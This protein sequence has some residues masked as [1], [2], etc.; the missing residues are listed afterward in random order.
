MENLPIPPDYEDLETKKRIEN[1]NA[2][3]KD[4][5]RNDENLNY[6]I[7]IF[8]NGFNFDVEKVKEKIK[9]DEMFAAHF[10][11]SPRKQRLHEKAAEEYLGKISVIKNFQKLSSH[12]IDSQHISEKG[13]IVSGKPFSSTFTKSL[14]FSWETGDYKCFAAHKFTEIRGGAQDNQYNDLGKT[15]LNYK[16]GKAKNNII[17]FI[18]C[19]GPYYTD[20]DNEKINELIKHTRNEKPKS[21][22]VTIHNIHK[23]LEGLANE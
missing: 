4:L 14:D 13:E 23:I 19:D 17:L 21:Y 10:T 16:T 22:V 8:A 6:K 3:K 7:K 11:K 2:V 5:E 1:L 20:N 15:L 12:G 9:N 18:I